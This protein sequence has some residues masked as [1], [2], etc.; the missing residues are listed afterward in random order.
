[1]FYILIILSYLIFDNIYINLS[2]IVITPDD[3]NIMY[4]SYLN[5]IIFTYQ[6]V[7]DVVKTMPNYI[8]YYICGIT[9]HNQI[10]NQNFPLTVEK[11]FSILRPE[12]HYKSGMHLFPNVYTY[13]FD[14]SFQKFDFRINAVNQVVYY[15]SNCSYY[16]ENL[17]IPLLQVFMDQHTQNIYNNILN[18]IPTPKSNFLETTVREQQLYLYSN[19][20]YYKN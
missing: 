1:M 16:P 6:D 14:W 9:E 20:W 18:A 19:P 15:Y 7:V 12:N 5:C 10:F 2:L 8:L 4:K 13:Y 11:L 3:V 17:R